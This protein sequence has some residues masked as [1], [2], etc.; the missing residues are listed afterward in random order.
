LRDGED[1]TL[2]SNGTVLWRALVA[3]AQLQDQRVSARVIFDG[4]RKPLDTE[5]VVRAAPETAGIVTAEESAAEGG[6]GA[7]WLRRSRTI[8]SK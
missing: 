6:L 3:A 5:A 1:V 4:Y 7:R 8:R 2:I